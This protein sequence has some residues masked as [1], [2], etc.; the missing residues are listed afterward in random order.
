MAEHI[1]PEM[2]PNLP[3]SDAPREDD[4]APPKS[5]P[6]GDERWSAPFDPAADAVDVPLA[7]E[8]PTAGDEGDDP[9]ST[10]APDSPEARPPRR[11]RPPGPA[12]DPSADATDFPL[13]GAFQPEQPADDDAAAADPPEERPEPAPDDPYARFRAPDSYPTLGTASSRASPW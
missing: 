3:G 12:I 5:P 7:G 4:P 11:S 13:A 2:D 8:F 10:V 6:S 9:G 1:D